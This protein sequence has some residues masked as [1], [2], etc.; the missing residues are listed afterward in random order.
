[1]STFASSVQ[2]LASSSDSVC[3][4]LIFPISRHPLMTVLLPV[5]VKLRISF[6]S[7]SPSLTFLS[8]K[9]FSI[10]FDSFHFQ[11]A[12]DC[13][14]LL[15]LHF[16]TPSGYRVNVGVKDVTSTEKLRV[17]YTIN[18]R[19]HYTSTARVVAMIHQTTMAFKNP[20]F[21]CFQSTSEAT[22]STTV[23][24]SIFF[25]DFGIF[26]ITEP[27]RLVASVVHKVCLVEVQFG[28]WVLRL[29][30]SVVRYS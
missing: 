7:I 23:M 27:G 5:S 12:R 17:S 14:S 26:I 24:N 25:I 6:D 15:I 21:V 1:M 28:F 13:V 3:C 20:F 22:V 29:W 30:S 16:H 18:P 11:S 10:T 9:L 19:W 4:R 8:D 2:V